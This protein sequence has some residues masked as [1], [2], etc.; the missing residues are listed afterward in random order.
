[1]SRPIYVMHWLLQ[2]VHVWDLPGC[3]GS[4]FPSVFNPVYSIA[5]VCSSV[6]FGLVLLFR[7]GRAS[8]SLLLLSLLLSLLLLLRMSIHYRYYYHYF[9]R[10]Y[11]H[12]FYRYYY[13]YSPDRHTDRKIHCQLV[14]CMVAKTKWRTTFFQV[15]SSIEI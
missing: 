10:Y 8:L 13:H 11:Y 7:L 15:S 1:M 5:R 2:S 6:L 12:Y 3:S 4:F 14:T 9:Y